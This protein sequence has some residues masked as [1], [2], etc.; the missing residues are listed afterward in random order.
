MTFASRTARTLAILTV[1]AAGTACRPDTDDARR[2]ARPVDAC[3]LLTQMDVEE[4]IGIPFE[5]GLPQGQASGHPGAGR[6]S[7]CAYASIASAEDPA[8]VLRN[9]TYVTVMI[10]TW[11]Q[12]ESAETYLKSME[13]SP[14][15]SPRAIEGL[16]ERAVWTGSL[17]ARQ[18]DASV[19]ITV[20]RGEDMGEAE[21]ITHE[22][23]LM[24]L[25][26][27]RLLE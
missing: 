26:L 14:M 27:A 10:W 4:T 2:E 19:T 17:S 9:T 16:G 7:S 12:K 15:R 21:E 5:P 3:T 23:A 8:A 11:P 22:T 1:L 20:N 24:R 25:I 13:M 18:G 6:M